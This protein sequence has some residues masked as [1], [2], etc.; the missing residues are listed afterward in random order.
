MQPHY[1]ITHVPI[2][3]VQFFRLSILLGEIGG[4]GFS[5]TVKDEYNLYYI[6]FLRIVVTTQL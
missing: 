5:G 4:K 6:V 3:N 1:I 2:V